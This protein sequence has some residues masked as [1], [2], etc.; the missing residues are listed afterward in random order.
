MSG[1]IMVTFHSDHRL[2][3][4]S[5]LHSPVTEEILR[6]LSG[7]YEIVQPISN[8]LQL[9]HMVKSGCKGDWEM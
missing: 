4:F 5:T 2:T 9:S 1:A 8:W 6:R 7:F 3:V